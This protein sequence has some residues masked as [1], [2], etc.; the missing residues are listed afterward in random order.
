MRTCP[1]CG[2]DNLLR[3]RRC[4]KCGSNAPTLPKERRLEQGYFLGKTYRFQLK[5]KINRGPD[6]E[7]W[8]AYDLKFRRQTIAL[9]IVD[10]EISEKRGAINALK[11]ASLH[12]IPHAH[13]NLERIH[14]FEND[15]TFAFFVVEYVQGPS[16]LLVWKKR[17]TLSEP[18]ILWVAREIATGL[19]YFHKLRLCHGNLNLSNLMLSQEP[20]QDNLPTIPTSRSH[21]H[22]CVKICDE[23][24]GRVIRD[25]K[26][27]KR[28]KNPALWSIR[29]DALCLGGILYR[30]YTGEDPQGF[31]DKTRLLSPLPDTIKQIISLCLEATTKNRDLM[32]DLISEIEGNKNAVNSKG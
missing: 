15:D 19:R 25:I 22:Q 27:G 28:H 8:L 16:L 14:S 6:S 4:M 13:P 1:A 18:E 10:R 21:P 29:E 23:V 11:K 17:K 12:V 30:L 9:K 5:D 31:N 3:A 24:I 20:P 26:E 2:Y 32:E 7:V